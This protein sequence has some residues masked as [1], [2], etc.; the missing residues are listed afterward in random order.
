M[1]SPSAR[2]QRD[3]RLLDS[4]VAEPPSP[5]MT[6]A[7]IVEATLG[8]PGARGALAAGARRAVARLGVEVDPVRLALA[9]DRATRRPAARGV[10][11]L[12]D[13]VVTDDLPVDLAATEAV[14]VAVT[15]AAGR[16]AAEVAPH[17][18]VDVAELDAASR[19]GRVALG[20]APQESGPTA[21]A[22]DRGV[23]LLALRGHALENVAAR[24][25]T[26]LP[27]D[28]P[29]R[30][31]PRRRVVEPAA[32]R[33]GHASPSGVPTASD[34]HAAGATH[35]DLED[36]PRVPAAEV[37]PA[38]VLAELGA[39]RGAAGTIGLIVQPVVDL[40]D[41]TTAG[42]E[43][44]V[45][46]LAPDGRVRPNGGWLPLVE[47]VG[48]LGDLSGWV[49]EAA[50]DVLDAWGTHPGAPPTLAVNLPP[51]GLL[52]PGLLHAVTEALARRGVPPR[53]LRIE[54]TETELLRDVLAARRRI[55][56]LHDLGIAL[57]LD[58]VG[59]GYSTL[60]HVRDLPIDGIKLDGSFTAEVDRT[61]R[62]RAIV[63]SLLGMARALDLRV[64]GEGVERD[65]Q[66]RALLELGCQLG[67]GFLL[68]RPVPP[69]RLEPPA[70]SGSDRRSSRRVSVST[71]D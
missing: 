39:S 69:S 13:L 54:L 2:L 61:P 35:L 62:G 7:A 52:D 16:T 4:L 53:R 56:E 12:A 21:L 3:L 29:A 27:D 38:A 36:A 50:V 15:V 42:A 48:M 8:T 1:T 6:R 18:G 58:D 33:G 59:T 70:R 26:G 37:L 32:P 11:L 66:R 24:I 68:G 51:S 44:L 45:R 31:P 9:V 64:V 19:R 30:V 28:D 57:D 47:Q 55:H 34:V 17:L 60:T 5:S 14:A 49:V 25:A 41:G 63:D 20:L 65:G 40:G 71:E 46:W 22:V 10:D 67:Q 23:A 43:A